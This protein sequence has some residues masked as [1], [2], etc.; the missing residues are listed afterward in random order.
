VNARSVPDAQWDGY[1]ILP[2]KGAHLAVSEDESLVV[3]AEAEYLLEFPPT[4]A[5]RAW[6]ALDLLEPGR[7]ILRFG[8]FIGESS[9]GGRRVLVT[10]N[11]LSSDEADAM[12]ADVVN[13]LHSLPFWY[14]TPVQLGYTRDVLAAE[15]VDYQA[16]TFLTHA[17]SGIGPHD[18]PTAFDRV[19]GRPHMRL[20]PILA[21]LPLA[22]AD[23]VDAETLIGLAS[24]ISPVHPIEA[25]SPLAHSPVALALGDRAPERVR[26]GRM[27]ET[28][29]TP[30]NQFV[31]AVIEVADGVIKRFEDAV[32]RDYPHRAHR[33]LEE[34]SSHRDLLDRWRRHPTLAPVSAARRLTTQSTVLRGRPGYRQVT[35]FFV[36]LQARTRLLDAEDA[37]RLL[38]VRDAALIYEYWC[39]FQV[40]D[41]TAAVLNRQPTPALFRHG[42]FGS[43]LVRAYAA[44]FGRARVWFNRSFERPRSDSVPLRPDITLEMAD[45]TLHLMDAKFKREPISVGQENE[46]A[47]E[48]EEQRATYRRGD[49]YKMHTYRDALDARSV[50]VLFPGRNVD[51]VHFEPDIAAEGGPAGVGAQPL[52][53]GRDDHQEDLKELIRDLLQTV[54]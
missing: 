26:A 27:I 8:N 31:V 3:L 53:P 29:N 44:D 5:E 38:E 32:R 52:L 10:S 50:W 41:A 2:R 24:G 37:R 28:T 54:A 51:R 15:D 7:A 21:T 42:S 16:Y 40:V 19:L 18:L 35:R 34:A 49:L 6:Q 12:F 33:Y 13:G 14:D 43:N 20:T 30:E 36:D 22:H 11:R 4:A 45:G 25:G 1:R 47:L 17:V 23:R 9:L 39:Y 46:S 48:E